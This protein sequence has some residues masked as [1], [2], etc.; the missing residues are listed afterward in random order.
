MAPQAQHIPNYEDEYNLA[1]A[2]EEYYAGRFETPAHKAVTRRTIY[3]A[4]LGDTE[5][6]A[7]QLAGGYLF[8]ADGQRQGRL[9]AAKDPELVLHGR[10]DL[11]DAQR[12]ADQARGGHAAIVCGYGR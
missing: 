6:T 12:V 7:E 11:A 3:Y 9:V 4:H 5:G 1:V 2:V 10:K 8:R